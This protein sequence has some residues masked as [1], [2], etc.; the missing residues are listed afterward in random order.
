MCAKTL[1]SLPGVTLSPTCANKSLLSW[2]CFWQLFLNLYPLPKWPLLVTSGEVFCK[3]SNAW[4]TVVGNSSQKRCTYW[5]KSLCRLSYLIGTVSRELTYEVTEDSVPLNIWIKYIKDKGENVHE[6]EIQNGVISKKI[7]NV[8][9][10]KIV[11][12]YTKVLELWIKI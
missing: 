11:F 4:V 1:L 3:R 7:N 9:H 10:V 5:L 8:E 12:W 6:G 2:P